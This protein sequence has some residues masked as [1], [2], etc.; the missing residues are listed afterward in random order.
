MP[1]YKMV[2]E[3]FSL[4][5][6]FQIT[7]IQS[8]VW[9]IVLYLF[10]RYIQTNIYIE[11]LYKYI[12][13]LENRIEEQAEVIFNRESKS[14]EVKYPLILNIIHII[15]VWIFPIMSILIITLK[16]YF[17]RIQNINIVP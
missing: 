13:Q 9:V 8:F 17:E 11:R 1:I 6:P 15:Y 14:Y 12:K 2:Q 10:M 3:Y 5:L 4:E 16:I 7:V